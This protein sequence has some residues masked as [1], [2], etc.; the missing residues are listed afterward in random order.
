MPKE[1]FHITNFLAGTVSGPSPQDIS[2]DTAQESTN[3]DPVAR[4]GILSSIP[5]DKYLQSG[6]F[7]DFDYDSG[8]FTEPSDELA[9]IASAM[10]LIADGTVHNLF[11]FD[12]NDSKIKVIKDLYAA[13]LTQLVV[14]MYDGPEQI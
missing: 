9:V 6:G 1:I 8:V 7:S 5:Q 3:I 11:Y 4:D 12:P 14:S 10:T 13:G 2:G